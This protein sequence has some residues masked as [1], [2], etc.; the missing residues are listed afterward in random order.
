MNAGS[1]ASKDSEW[2]GVGWEGRVG[3]RKDH[4]RNTLGNS[5]N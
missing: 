1:L 5:Q 3:M 4:R 2:S